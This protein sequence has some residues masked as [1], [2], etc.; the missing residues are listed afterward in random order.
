MYIPYTYREILSGYCKFPPPTAHY[1]LGTVHFN[2]IDTG[3]RR[4]ALQSNSLFVR[5]SANAILFGQSRSYQ[6]KVKRRENMACRS[7]PHVIKSKKC[8]FKAMRNEN[9]SKLSI[10]YFY[11]RLRQYFPELKPKKNM[12]R[13]VNVILNTSGT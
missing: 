7:F 13:R 8:F 9:I 3:P 11:G 5:L 2:P 4:T 12:T 1:D 10:T 6:L